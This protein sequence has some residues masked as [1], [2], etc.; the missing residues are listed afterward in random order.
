MTPV[1]PGHPSALGTIPSTWE[2]SVE[3]WIRTTAGARWAGWAEAA[4][5]ARRDAA[6][7]PMVDRKALACRKPP[8][9]RSVKKA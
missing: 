3:M 7:V 9:K 8:H 6:C 5:A 4:G 1:H 2:L